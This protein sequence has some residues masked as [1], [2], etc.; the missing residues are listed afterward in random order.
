MRGHVLYVRAP[1]L[2]HC[3][4]I[5]LIQILNLQPNP[6]ARTTCCMHGHQTY[7]FSDWGVWHARLKFNYDKISLSLSFLTLRCIRNSSKLIDLFPSV[8]KRLNNSLI[9]YKTKRKQ[10]SKERAIRIVQLTSIS[11]STP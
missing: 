2:K 6:V 11:R 9:S 1:P 7:L 4:A 3:Q 8:S 5:K 10:M